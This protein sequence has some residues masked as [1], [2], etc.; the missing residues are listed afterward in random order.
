MPR[1]NGAIL[2]CAVPDNDMLYD[3]AAL[4]SGIPIVLDFDK[5]EQVVMYDFIARAAGIKS[6]LDFVGQEGKGNLD[7]KNIWLADSSDLTKALLELEVRGSDVEKIIRSPNFG[8]G[9]PERVNHFK[10][11]GNSMSE[12]EFLDNKES[13]I[14]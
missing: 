8:L 13:G 1:F 12:A 5:P 2:F 14:P 4:E 10:N 3:G 7:L 9:V 11:E 6:P